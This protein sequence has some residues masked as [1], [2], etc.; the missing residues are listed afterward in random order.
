MIGCFVTIALVCGGG[1]F[2]LMSLLGPDSGAVSE[3]LARA[4]E[5]HL[6]VKPAD[7]KRS[8]PDQENAAPLYTALFNPVNKL[9]RTMSEAWTKKAKPEAVLKAKKALATAPDLVPKIIE[10][11]QRPHCDFKKDYSLGAA[12]M[13]AEYAPMR[14]MVKILLFQAVE[15]SKAGNWQQSLSLVAAANRI[16]RH[17]Q[18]EPSM[19]GQLVA[20]S[21]E[22]MIHRA[23]ERIFTESPN[24]A[25]KIE[26]FLA[27]SR[28][29]GPLPD[30]RQG[31]KGEIVFAQVTIP[32][33][34]SWRQL[35]SLTGMNEGSTASK[36]LDGLDF[37]IP[38]K[39]RD[40]W[41]ARHLRVMNDMFAKFP[42]QN[43]WEKI[44]AVMEET[45]RVVMKDESLANKMNQIF[46]PVFSQAGIAVGRVA[47]ERNL[48][49]TSLELLQAQAAG[50]LPENLEKLGPESADPFGKKKLTYRREGKGFLLYSVGTDRKDD[51]GLERGQ[52]RN[53]SN[54]SEGDMIRRYR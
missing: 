42:A 49:I 44:S 9:S 36:P 12:V 26:K 22:S 40:S 38:E 1:Y 54:G 5:M 18:E 33:I 23:I 51:G 28:G 47:A 8:V 34:K 2:I 11:S 6:P 29:L 45:D 46:M 53:S 17:L 10:A 39:L 21:S 35:N 48:T 37:P 32:T 13:F 4:Q 7:L 20:I 30:M 24:P 43:D 19:I 31:L 27:L 14:V 50:S 41:R 3:Q 25:E 16:E 15:A 52:V